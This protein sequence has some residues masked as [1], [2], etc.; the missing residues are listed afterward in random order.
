MPRKPGPGG[1]PCRALAV[2]ALADICG[3]AKLGT[4]N[5]TGLTLRLILALA[6]AMTGVPVHGAMEAVAGS[7]ASDSI[8]KAAPH[9]DSTGGGCPHES[10]A[11]PVQDTTAENHS[12]CLGD[13]CCSSDCGCNCIGLS[14]VL[15]MKRSSV[16]Q[17]MPISG[18]PEAGSLLDSLLVTSL[19]RP[20]QA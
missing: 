12:D 16:G 15:P 1:N 2:F 3:H 20:P 13:D 7:S 5:P 19:L 17:P 14:L 4:M 6:L 8:E 11:A 10:G 9:T 18:P